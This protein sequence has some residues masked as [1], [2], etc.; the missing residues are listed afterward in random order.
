MQGID[1]Q[2]MSLKHWIVLFASLL[3]ILA[4]FL[5]AYVKS[6]KMQREHASSSEKR[7]HL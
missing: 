3:P 7:S 4:S 5:Y 6:G 1:T 2:N